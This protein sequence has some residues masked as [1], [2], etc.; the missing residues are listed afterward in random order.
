MTHTLPTTN[1]RQLNR[2]QPSLIDAIHGHSVREVASFHTPGHK[3]R[4]ATIDFMSLQ[5]DVTELPGLDDLTYPD[6]VIAQLESRAA[7]IWQSGES[8][9]SI[10][11]SSAV[12]MA[13]ILSCTA[14]GSKLVLPRNAHRSCIHA[15]V[16]SGLE[17]VW[18]E[19]SWDSDLGVFADVSA[20][21]F[22]E[23]IR[24]GGSDVAAALVVTPTFAGAISDVGM[25]A[26]I[27]HAHGV[28]LIVD[29]AHGGHLPSHAVSLGAD[30]TIHSLHK[31]LG[32]LTQT[33]V[34][35]IATRSLVPAERVRAMLRLL[36]SSSPSYLLMSSIDAAL[37][38][39]ETIG[40]PALYDR[41][42]C[43][44]REF[45]TQCRS[46]PHLKVSSPSGKTDPA[47][48]LIAHEQL[49]PEKLYNALFEAGICAETILG[50]AVLLLLGAGSTK[51]D[52]NACI[53][54]LS[55]LPSHGSARAFE[56][57]SPPRFA[58]Q[59]LPVRR[60]YLATSEFVEAAQAIGRIAADCYAPCPPGTAAIVP[61]QRIDAHNLLVFGEKTRIRV[62]VES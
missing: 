19:P 1:G 28:P 38:E 14:Q 22:E 57:L 27:A 42:L 61:G 16:L 5:N 54:A 24:A 26:A 36:Q 32:A 51:S 49:S 11:G 34:V 30:I 45:E 2:A 41:F 58:E 56:K 12:I 48:L 55:A 29:E 50:Q 43:L 21:S 40:L 3:T 4:L 18:Y 44:A 20:A 47:H 7:A 15:L 25:L 23:A 39:L 60:A 9:I 37:T 59:A 13:A 6:G 53:E 35:H 10:N 52:V 8:I 31:T 46:L 33:G 62:V 17:P